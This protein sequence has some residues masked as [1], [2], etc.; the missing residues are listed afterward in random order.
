MTGSGGIIAAV[1]VVGFVA[2]VSVIP[3][4]LIC[5]VVACVATGGVAAGSAGVLNSAPQRLVWCFCLKFYSVIWRGIVKNSV[6]AQAFSPFL[7][8]AEYPVQ[9]HSVQ[10][11]VALC[12]HTCI[13]RG[14]SRIF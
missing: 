7:I 13:L 4:L 10:K 14:R 2:V 1:T 5:V 3:V 6:M 9:H 11:N 8:A 12:K